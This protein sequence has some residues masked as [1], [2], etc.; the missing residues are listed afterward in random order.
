MMSATLGGLSRRA[1]TR[2]RVEPPERPS[3]RAPRLR[4]PRGRHRTPR[5]ARDSTPPRPRRRSSPQT[6]PDRSPAGRRASSS[7]APAPGSSSA[8]RARASSM[9]R[10]DATAISPRR[11]LPRD[12]PC[13]AFAAACRLERRRSSE[14][15]GSS[16]RASFL[17]RRREIRRR[18]R[19]HVRGRVRKA[20]LRLP[21]PLAA[22]PPPRS[23]ALFARF[24]KVGTGRARLGA[25][26]RASRSQRLRADRHPAGTASAAPPRPSRGSAATASWC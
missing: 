1:Q 26:C 14:T 13:R 11:R 23:S 7:A 2:S 12:P 9:G 19:R 8:A 22:S 15:A 4:R 24:R 20:S 5:G 10:P 3:P 6:R 25:R 21:G 18:F 17:V 16:R